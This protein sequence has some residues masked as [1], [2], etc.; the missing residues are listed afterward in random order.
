VITS[1]GNDLK[2]CRSSIYSLAHRVEYGQVDGYAV[3]EYVTKHEHVRA[4]TVNSLSPRPLKRSNLILK[5]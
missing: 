3:I 4:P 2:M 5:A 1:N